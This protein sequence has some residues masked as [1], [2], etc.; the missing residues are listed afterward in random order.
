M[1]NEII[2][3]SPNEIASYVPESNMIALIQSDEF[4]KEVGKNTKRKRTIET[5]EVY[6]NGYKEFCSN[7]NYNPLLQHSLL[8]YL[9]DIIKSGRSVKTAETA[10]Y[11]NIELFELHSAR[12]DSYLFANFFTGVKNIKLENNEI[13]KKKTKAIVLTDLID[14]L[15]GISEAYKIVLIWLYFGAFRV[16]ELLNLN[17]NDIEFRTEGAYITIRQAKNLKAGRTQMKF[18]PRIGNGN[19]PVGMMEGFLKDNGG[20]QPIFKDYSRNKVTM[21]IS[22]K[23]AGCGSHSLRAGFV[24]DAINCGQSL[25]QICRQTGQTVATAQSYID[26]IAVNQNNAVNELAKKFFDKL[27]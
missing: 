9:K 22:R 20:K 18:I 5:Y 16:T 19:C 12:L 2:K 24:T 14:K 10:Y 8:F 25:E 6:R 21:Y 13:I 1:K 17:E 15:P 7:N 11:A 3:S 4:F 23:F 27:S 26:N